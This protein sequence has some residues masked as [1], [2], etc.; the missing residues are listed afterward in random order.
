M[1]RVFDNCDTASQEP[2]IGDENWGRKIADVGEIL[3][4]VQNSE[5]RGVFKNST[6]TKIIE[7]RPASP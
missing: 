3:K 7:I 5:L 4:F 6:K 2:K 1:M